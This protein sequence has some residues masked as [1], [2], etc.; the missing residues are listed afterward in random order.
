MLINYVKNLI[1]LLHIC[2]SYNV[3]ITI[4]RYYALYETYTDRVLYCMLLWYLHI[5]MAST[6]CTVLLQHAAVTVTAAAAAWRMLSE[7]QSTCFILTESA[8]HKL[9]EA[10]KK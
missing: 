7:S 3:Y 6:S 4:A 8:N 2:I 10:L 5:C 1:I 9:K